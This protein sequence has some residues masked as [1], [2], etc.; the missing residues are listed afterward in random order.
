MSCLNEEAF[1]GL[2]S[3]LKNEAP[4]QGVSFF[5]ELLLFS[6]DWL[7]FSG[8][9]GEDNIIVLLALFIIIVYIS[10]QLLI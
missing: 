1:F 4:F 5:S 6:S 9:L 2:A 8:I 7:L 10:K 3:S